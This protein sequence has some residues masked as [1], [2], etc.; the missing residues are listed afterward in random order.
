L[1]IDSARASCDTRLD[2][3]DT[4]TNTEF[5]PMHEGRMIRKTSR[6]AAGLFIA[7]FAFG[8]ASGHSHDSWTGP[9]VAVPVRTEAWQ[10]EGQSGKTLFTPHYTIHTTIDDE[11]FL[12]RLPQV[13]EGG[14]QQYQM[15]APEVKF[16]DHPM[17]CYLFSRRGEWADFTRE[18]TGMDAKIYLQINRGG[19][20]IRDWF[21]AYFIGDAG[22]YSV[23]AHEGW[24]QYSARNFK[25]RLP[26]FMEEGVATQFENIHWEGDLPR[27]NIHFNANRA[28]RLRQAVDGKYLWPLE[29]LVTMHAGDVVSLGGDKIEAFYAQN[30]AFV[31]FAWDA[32]NGKYRPAF[33]KMLT[34]SA[35]GALYDPSGGAVRLPWGAWR[36]QLVKPILEHYFGMSLPDLNKAYQAYV[37]VIAYEKFNEQWQS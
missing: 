14:F 18:H 28:Q 17:E 20:T 22:T 21:V 12:Q 8:C 5:A 16:S 4:Q 15:L 11:H 27:W 25:N 35:N 37:H 30:W 7:L 3:D 19:Y 31:R 34:D 24:H 32:E 1:C 29:Q 10:Y 9:A 23:S 33:Q 2:P 6:F 26:P 36:P 13:M